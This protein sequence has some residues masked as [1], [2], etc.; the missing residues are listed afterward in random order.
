MGNG[1]NQENAGLT[2]E[3]MLKLSTAKRELQEDLDKLQ[4]DME[5]ARRR[6]QQQT[7]RA[8]EQLAR[9]AQELQESRTA[10]SLGRSARD[11]ERGRGVEAVTREGF[12]GEAL[13]NVEQQLAEAADLAANES[14]RGR[15]QGRQADAGDLLAE[16]GELR[17]AFERAQQGAAA[18]QNPA[19]W[20]PG[21]HCAEPA[22][23]W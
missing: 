21:H 12:I 5:S 6:S 3:Q 9:T 13:Q 23:Q 20:R 18:A 22:R 15:Q 2:F 16:I 8:S 14:G 17:R 4:A 10:D 11:I 19:R 1:R 7:P